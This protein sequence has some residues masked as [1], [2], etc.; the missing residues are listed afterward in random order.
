M[1][2]WMIGYAQPDRT[3]LRILQPFRHFSSCRQNERVRPRRQRFDQ[4]VSPVID[5]CIKADLGQVRANQREVVF[6]VG[7]SDPPDTIDCLSI[8]YVTSERVAGICRVGDQ[9]PAL[10]GANN[11]RNASRLRIGGVH[12]DEFGHA[13]IVGEQGL[14]G[15]PLDTLLFAAF[16]HFQ[17]NCR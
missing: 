4:S 8:S 7:L 12:F 11:H 6:L 1:N 9:P 5:P 15:Y 16:Q 17:T 2:Q 14:R 10:Y 13:R 3:S